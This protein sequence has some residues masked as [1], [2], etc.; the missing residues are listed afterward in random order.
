[1]AEILTFK[2]KY[3]IDIITSNAIDFKALRDPKGKVIMEK[4]KFHKE[5]NSLKINRFSIQYN[6]SEGEILQKLKKIPSFNSLNLSDIIIKK[7]VKNGPYHGNL[8]DHFLK[9]EKMNYDIIHTTFFPYFNLIVSLIVGRIIN[10]PVICTPFFH[11]SNP[12]YLDS[13][14]V[15]ILK[16]FDVIIACTNLEK[17]VLVKK[18]KIQDEK[19]KVIS[20][21]VDNKIYEQVHSTKLNQYYFKQNFFKKKEKNYKLVLYCGN[22]NYEKGAL[23]I[24][25][26]I[27]YILEKIKRVYFVFI[28]P[29]TKAFNHELSKIQKYRN[30]R[31]INFSPDN[32][33][34]YY[35]KKKLT[36][37]KE[38]DLF[39]MPS[40]SDAFGI[41]FL[42]AWAAG[43]PVI[44]ARIGAT[45]EV[46]REN[47][48][49]LLVEFDDPIDTAQ[50]VIKL[51]KN[52]KLRK[53]L[54]SAG[55]LK[56][57]Q[58]YTWEIVAK[59]THQIYQNLIKRNK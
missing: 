31:I 47:I 50:K 56:V 19:I 20:M 18:F 9:Q 29:S 10:K 5:V 51:L 49:G 13:T 55:Q 12:R 35:D 45:P 2:F 53:K 32:L 36:A 3:K 59:K 22:K 57:S 52:K 16:K 15:E 14:L 21:G 37:F 33:T 54:G 48:D 43:I 17:E 7:F 44:G 38:A 8:I 30:S 4:N 1:M 42:E 24:L 40:R 28:G 34:G 25:K 58:N 41:A 23:T 39:L 26:A 46:I 6:I 11:F 27:P